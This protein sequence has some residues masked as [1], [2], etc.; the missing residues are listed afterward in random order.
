MDQI[1]LIKVC[2][3]CNKAWKEKVFK[4][5]NL[6]LIIHIILAYVITYFRQAKNYVMQMKIIIK[7][8]GLVS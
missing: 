8:P 3:K 4:S 7:M 1:P 5:L 6:Q 2:K